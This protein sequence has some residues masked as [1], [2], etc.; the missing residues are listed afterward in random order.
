MTKELL[1]KHKGIDHIVL[2]DDEDFPLLSRHSW[3]LVSGI[4]NRMYAYAFI[5]SGNGH[6][7]MLQMTHLIMGQGWCIDHKNNNP[8]DNRKDNLRVATKQQNNWN[9]PKMRSRCGKPTSSQYK[10]VYKTKSERGWRSA[11]K[12]DGKCHPLGYFQTEVEAAIAYNEAASRLH[13]EWAWLNPV[14][15]II[16]EGSS[17]QPTEDTK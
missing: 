11:I 9:T 13:G 12:H 16:H 10:G 5:Y 2:V 14:P 1:A 4:N 6:R 15:S 3:Y 8:L 7:K 17:V